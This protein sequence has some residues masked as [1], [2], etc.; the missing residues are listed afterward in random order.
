MDEILNK[1]HELGKLIAESEVLG[2]FQERELSFLSD[3][4]AQKAVQQYDEKS[5]Q[6]AEDMHSASM[7]PE[8]LESFRTRMNENMAE[9]TQNAIAKEYLEAKSAFNRL[10][11][12]V[13]EI[14]AFHIRGEEA[15]S[16]GCSG[17][18]SGCSGC[19]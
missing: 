16:G 9:L 11:T 10:I 2:S 8:L 4:E 12:Q 3:E 19:H 7:T 1:A 18:C 14:I 17:N 6:L 15:N 5:K 13:N